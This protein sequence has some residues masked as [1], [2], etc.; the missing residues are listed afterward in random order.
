MVARLLITLLFYLL[1]TI[2]GAENSCLDCHEPHY[3]K[4]G[5]CTFCHTGNPGT[6]R[7]NIAHDR[8]IGKRFAFYRDKNSAPVEYGQKLVKSS[9]CR[10][11]HTFAGEGNRLA[12]NLDR[13][14]DLYQPAEISQAIKQ[15]AFYMP[16]FRFSDDQVDALINAILNA[17]TNAPLKTHEEPLR[18]HFESENS[19]KNNLFVDKCGACHKII[20][21]KGGGLGGGVVGPNLSGLL[22]KYYPYPFKESEGWST[23]NLEKWLKNPRKIK[24]NARMLPIKLKVDELPMLFKIIASEES[25][26]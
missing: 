26:K 18:I 24:E 12:S 6:D 5:R 15:P 21:F 17:G 16:D 19:V 3:V 13:V 23:E 20:S 9:G 25:G 2:A 10:R 7:K 1:T 4:A 11:C 8:L 22:S 14:A